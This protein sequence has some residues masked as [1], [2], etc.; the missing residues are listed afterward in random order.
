MDRYYEAFEWL[1]REYGGRP[2]WAKNF[3]QDS[4]QKYLSS[5]YGKDLESWLKVR[6][7]VDPDG[8]FLGAWHRRNVLPVSKST[9]R[10]EEREVH[11]SLAP[12]GG[13]HWVGEM[14]GNIGEKDLGMVEEQH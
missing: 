11:R 3:T 10:C 9:Y 1:M 14:N 7:D 4:G 12:D 13:Q 5:A 8:V 2:H 6:D